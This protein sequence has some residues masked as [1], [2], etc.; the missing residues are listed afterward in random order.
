M[1]TPI[2]DR[3]PWVITPTALA[4]YHSPRADAARMQFQFTAK[5]LE[6]VPL[7]SVADGIATIRVHGPLM[8]GPD[9]FEQA[10]YGALDTE[11]IAEAIA[12]VAANDA[13]RV[14]LFDFDCPGGQVT[15][16]PEVAAAIAAL[17]KIK[18]TYAFTGGMMASGAYYLASQCDEILATPSARVGSIGVVWTFVDQSKAYAEEGLAVQVFSTGKY[19][20]TGTPGTSLTSDQADYMQAMVEEIFTDFKTAVLARGRPISEESMQGQLF[21]GKQGA[22]AGLCK[23]TTREALGRR[24]GALSKSGSRGAKMSTAT[25]DI[26]ASA[27]PTID[28]PTVETEL[29]ARVA[30]IATLTASAATVGAELATANAEVAR[31]TGLE[32]SARADLAAAQALMES[33]N[34]ELV[35][36]RA[37][38][39]TATRAND[40]FDARVATRAA[41]IAAAS[42]SST[43]AAIVPG[44]AEKAV[45]NAR[46]PA[47]HQAAMAAIND[48]TERRAYY[49]AHIKGK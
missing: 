18:Y 27:M 20:A 26:R 11:E 43:P 48:P 36:V 13:V 30:E 25:I 22:K 32:A 2:Q 23:V 41:E 38:L 10:Y 47:E 19:K 42:G 29:A 21:S 31:L 7:V 46:T 1:P 14:V 16:T 28:P 8:R 44:D 17:S 24:L 33:A 34:T 49:L 6:D 3:N 9:L 12:E 35:T 5:G 37:S 15:G 40:D 45:V 4:E 39:A